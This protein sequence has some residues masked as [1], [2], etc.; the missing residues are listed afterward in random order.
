MVARHLLHSLRDRGELIGAERRRNEHDATVLAIRGDELSD[1]LG[2]IR[3]VARDESTAGTGGVQELASIVEL[4]VVG[5]LVS[6]HGVE[7]TGPEHL[8]DARRQILVE[9]ERHLAVTTRTSPG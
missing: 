5:N 3:D 1:Q 7:P 9:V 2:E 6:A 4:D 8:G